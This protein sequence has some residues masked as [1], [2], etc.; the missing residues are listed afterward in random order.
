MDFLPTGTILM[1]GP[2]RVSKGERG[3]GQDVNV[4]KKEHRLKAGKGVAWVAQSV[5]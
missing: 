3:D 5:K 2:T 4:I 1:E